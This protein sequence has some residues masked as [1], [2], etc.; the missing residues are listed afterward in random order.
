MQ[1]HS[2][3]LE[4]TEALTRGWP[5]RYTLVILMFVAYLI[6]WSDRVNFSVAAP[7]IMETYGWSKTQMG[8]V[9]SAFT[10][11]FVVFQLPAGWLA[12][13]YGG[14]KSMIGGILSWSVVT[15]LFPFSR[16]IASMSSL[17]FLLGVG[18]IT[19]PPSQVKIVARWFPVSER[20]KVNG[21]CLAASD[22]GVILATPL[23][24][25]LVVYDWRLVF[26]CFG[27]AGILWGAVIWFWSAR[28]ERENQLGEEVRLPAASTDAHSK[29]SFR[30]LVRLRTI[31]G[32]VLAWMCLTYCFWMFLNWLPT[33][34]VE[35]QGLTF[36]R[37]GFYSVLPFIGKAIAQ[38][39]AGWVSTSLLARGFSKNFSRKV[40]ICTGFL[41]AALCLV[42]T[43]FALSPPLAIAYISGAVA[44]LGACWTSIW[45]IPSD[46]SAR[47]PATIFGFIGTIGFLGSVAAPIMTG[48]IVDV[49][50]SWNYAFYVAAALSVVGFLATWLLVS[51]DPIDDYLTGQ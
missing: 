12:D 18:E 43:V 2:I 39:A 46:L 28:P 25:W 19:Y 24:A 3:S 13:R 5:T 32:L 8:F 41:G 4:K 9:L 6:A 38:I 20:S 47:W 29:L 31:W 7:K 50:Q 22:A 17:R 11:G 35:E 15:L 42:L 48:Y 33:Y 21:I 45:T 49:T 51:T 16:G 26:Y 40:I 37:M 10:W 34:L 27:A 30:R 23:A 1:A 14:L 44:L 36:I